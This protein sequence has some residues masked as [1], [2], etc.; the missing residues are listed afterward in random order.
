MSGSLDFVANDITGLFAK[1]TLNKQYI[2]VGTDRCFKLTRAKLTPE[3]TAMDISN[4]I[5]DHWLAPYDIPAYIFTN[6]GTHFVSEFFATVSVSLRG[7]RSNTTA[8]L[9]QTSR[10]AEM[11]N[12]T[13][14]V[15]LWDYDAEHPKD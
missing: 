9:P 15:R 10:E 1:T 3:K 13:V 14:F 7:K 12:L 8:Y 5:F 11:F 6:N 2:V 4:I